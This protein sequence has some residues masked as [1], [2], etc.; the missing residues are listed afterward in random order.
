MALFKRSTQGK[1]G[2]M[3]DIIDRAEVPA[4]PR[5]T[6]KII[7]KLRDAEVC[8]ADVAESLQWDA[9]LVARILRTVNSA[10]Y[11][12]SAPIVDVRHAVSFLGRSQLEQLIIAL[13]VRSALP[14]TPAPGFDPV[15]FWQLASFRAALS[16]TLA[17]QLHPSKQAQSFTAGLLQDMAVPLLASR[18]PK[19][20]GAVLQA[21]HADSGSNLEEL[22]EQAFGWNHA[23][24]GGALGRAWSLPAELVFHVESHHREDLLDSE[25]PAAVKLVS[26]LRES[27]SE[28]GVEALIE[29]A[30]T[31]YGLAP[32][33]L[34]DALER[35]AAQALELSRELA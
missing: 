19:A 16:R 14:S 20:Y 3:E 17:D 31:R 5:L 21:W 22:E 9:A 11:G 8:F 26:V 32:D 15:R 7:A 27:A 10:A 30:R 1:L 35:C 34:V 29:E 24:V 2:G 23:Q 33:W 25:L 4:F 12:T 28:S 18:N 13:A 6:L